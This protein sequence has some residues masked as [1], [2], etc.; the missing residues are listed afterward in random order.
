MFNNGQMF[1]LVP[2]LASRTTLPAVRAGVI[3]LTLES[4]CDD[5]HAHG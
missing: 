5:A 3:A 1:A 2:L 4:I